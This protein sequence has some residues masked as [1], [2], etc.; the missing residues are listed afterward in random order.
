MQTKPNIARGM[1]RPNLVLRKLNARGM[2]WSKLHSEDDHRQGSCHHFFSRFRWLNAKTGKKPPR[3]SPSNQIHRVNI[4]HL[5]HVVR[6]G[7]PRAK[8]YQLRH[9]LRHVAGEV[10]ELI[11]V[12]VLDFFDG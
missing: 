12:L 1:T 3:V 7:E 2:W 10:P 11:A 5:D 9:E 4:E 6:P 8:F